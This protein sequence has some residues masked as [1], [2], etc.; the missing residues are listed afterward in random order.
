M[1]FK[2]GFS[3]LRH[4]EAEQHIEEISGVAFIFNQKFFNDLHEAKGIDLENIVYYKDE[5]HYFVMTAKKQSLIDKGVITENEADTAKLLAAENINQ[6]KLFEYAR[7]AADFATEYQMPHLDFAVNHY[8]KPDVAMF[9]FTSMFQVKG[10]L[11][12]LLALLTQMLFQAEN[13]CRVIERHG[14]RLLT[15]LVGDS[16]LE[17]FWPTGTGCARG[18][19]GGLDAC[20][21]MRTLALGKVTALEAIAERESIYKLLAQS[22]P[23]NT[24]KDFASYTVDPRTRYPT[25]NTKLLS[26]HQVTHLVDTDNPSQLQEDLTKNTSTQAVANGFNIRRR[27][28]STVTPE[29]LLAWLTKQ[30]ESYEKV[31]ISDMTTSFQNG[32][33]LCAIIH[34]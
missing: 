21:M 7:E 29:A 6:D 1:L 33:A 10:N 5:T 32:L 34:R 22:T 15:A 26:P 24:S 3:Y 30:V 31:V 20:W 23:A 9:D 8:G 18:F 13:S 17:P 28:E 4:T 25:L 12:V 19:F 16:L 2:W 27:K 11:E 14:H